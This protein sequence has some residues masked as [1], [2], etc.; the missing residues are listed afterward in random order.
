VC[1]VVLEGGTLTSSAG[2]CRGLL[3][4]HPLCGG[5]VDRS[6][7]CGIWFVGTLLGPEGTGRPRMWGVLG[8]RFR[9]VLF[10]VPLCLLWECAGLAGAWGWCLVGG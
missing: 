7:G 5:C 3:V 8:S 9:A 10:L 2:P 4:R 6:L 1:G